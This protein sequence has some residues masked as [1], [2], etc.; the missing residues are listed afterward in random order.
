M[1]VTKK[2]MLDFSLL[3]FFDYWF[4]FCRL[5]VKKKD[6]KKKETLLV[7]FSCNFHVC[8]HAGVPKKD[9]FCKQSTS[10]AFNTRI[11]IKHGN[12]KNNPDTLFIGNGPGQRVKVE[13]S[14][15]HRWVNTGSFGTEPHYA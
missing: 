6:L 1:P 14:T 11:S 2:H 12:N 7:T 8:I 9:K 3:S 15:R 4:V 10:S 13:K 5:K